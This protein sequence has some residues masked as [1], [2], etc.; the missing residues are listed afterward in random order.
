MRPAETNS[1]S[2]RIDK[3][4]IIYIIKRIRAR[5]RFSGDLEAV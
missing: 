1:S 2:F 4:I 3:L 5:E